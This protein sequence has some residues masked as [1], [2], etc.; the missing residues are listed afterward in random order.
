[1]NGSCLI[2]FLAG[3]EVDMIPFNHQIS[4]F[5]NNDV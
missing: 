3:I 2:F 5:Q 4:H 1:M